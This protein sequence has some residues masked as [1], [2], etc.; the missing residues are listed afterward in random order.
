MRFLDDYANV[1]NIDNL[2]QEYILHEALENTSLKHE[3][4]IK[5][6]NKI[7][8]NGSQE[9][10]LGKAIK[11]YISNY[12]NILVAESFDILSQE[13]KTFCLSPTNVSDM[14][15]SMD[16][17]KNVERLVSKRAN[18]SIVARNYKMDDNEHMLGLLDKQLENFHEEVT[19]E[20]RQRIKGDLYKSTDVPIFTRFS[21][22]VLEKDKESVLNRIRT[23]LSDLNA[24]E[25]IYDLDKVMN[26]IKVIVIQP[27]GVE[28]FNTVTDLFTDILMMDADRYMQKDY[29]SDMPFRLKDLLVRFLRRSANNFSDLS[30]ENLKEVLEAIFSS[31]KHLVIRPINWKNFDLWKKSQDAILYSA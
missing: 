6:T 10:P 27:E 22:R 14:N 15:K 25:Q 1:N 9:N 4:I 12:D 7:F 8:H 2:V 31:T 21:I 24:E 19:K 13:G 18:S 17:D 20:I 28:H 23:K 16:I 5:I 3:Q 30:T 26:R 29:A 11:Y